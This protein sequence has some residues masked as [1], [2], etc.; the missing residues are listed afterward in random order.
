[1]K[2]A[3]AAANAAA[4]DKER[5]WQINTLIDLIQGV[6]EHCKSLK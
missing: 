2:G 6:P 5:E 1:M 3:A 4:R